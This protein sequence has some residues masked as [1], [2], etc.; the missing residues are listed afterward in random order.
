MRRQTLALAAIVGAV[1]ACFGISEP[2]GGI[3][4]IS[5]VL[6]PA[7]SVVRGDTMRDSTGAAAPLRAYAFNTAGDTIT[8]IV[9]T[10]IALGKRL[11][12]DSNG[13]VI[14]DTAGK[15]TVGVVATLGPVQTP[16]RGII[17]TVPPTTVAAATQRDTIEFDPFATD[18][19]SVGKSLTLTL[20]GPGDSV[21]TGF[22][23]VYAIGHAP[24][25]RDTAPAAMV[26]NGRTRSP[27]DT[28]DASGQAARTAAINRN[29][30]D[31]AW[32]SAALAA[33]PGAVLDSI[34]IDATV[35]T[36]GPVVAG[37][38]LTYVVI[39]RRKGG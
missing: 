8:S 10:W 37:N 12:V 3:A 36:R 24:P 6:L 39:V 7:P 26:V 15:D 5:P 17:V 23:V 28:T 32:L 11:H 20:T 30:V 19:L 16:P 2:P 35:Q 9:P 22:I 25:A 1:A 21:A 13:Y 33:D 34:V 14:G 4:S 38:P 31:P 27:R 29:A 18:S